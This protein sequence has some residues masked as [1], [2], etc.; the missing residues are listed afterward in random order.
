[1]DDFRDYADQLQMEVVS[2]MAESYFGSRKDLEDKIAA[3]EQM[4]EEFRS[5]IPK[6]FK[7]ASR[8]HMLLLDKATIRD[9]YIALDILPSCIPFA[10]E[11]NSTTKI[12]IPFAFTMRGRYERCLCRAYHL[13]REVADE[14]LNGHYYDD[15]EN[16]GR[17]RLTVHYLRLKALAEYI[18][19]EVERVNN[20][21]P[22]SSALEYVKQMDTVQM[23]R[24]NIMGEACDVQGCALDRDLRFQPVDFE[25]YELPV[26][27]DLPALKSVQPAIVSFSREIYSDRKADVLDLLESIK[28]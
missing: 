6:L 12:R 5:N 24:E 26:V 21:L 16:P 11:Y 14:Y 23:E 19:E 17:K 7:A 8:L 28:E 2:E 3:F 15:P 27:Q 25:A 20:A 10:D 9:F 1:M 18:N 13:F 4:V 22:P